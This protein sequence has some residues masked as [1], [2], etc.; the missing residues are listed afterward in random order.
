MSRR[1]VCRRLAL[2]PIAAAVLAVFALVPGGP[3]PGGQQPAVFI[4]PSSTPAATFAGPLGSAEQLGA[5][6]ALSA[7]GQVALIGAP[8]TGGGGAAYLYVESGGTWPTTP[9][10]TFT[11]P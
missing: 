2:G 10:E 3:K 1:E 5:S 11:G 8:A 6:V 4:P 9:T 7:D